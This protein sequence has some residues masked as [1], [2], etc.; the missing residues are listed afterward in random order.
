MSF[1]LFWAAQV[2]IIVILLCNA[3]EFTEVIWRPHWL[4]RAHPRSDDDYAAF[5][6]AMQPNEAGTQVRF[7]DPKVIEVYLG[8]AE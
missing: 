2:A 5:S 3:F 1:A 4:R 8:K 6:L 7:D